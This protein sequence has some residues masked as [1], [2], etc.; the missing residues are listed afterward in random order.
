MSVGPL[1]LMNTHDLFFGNLTQDTLNELFQ[2]ASPNPNTDKVLLQEHINNRL[3]I[4]S[5]YFCK[6]IVKESYMKQT[7]NG[8]KKEK[9]CSIYINIYNKNYK[10]V[11]SDKKINDVHLT[12]HFFKKMDSDDEKRLGRIHIRNI[13][14]NRNQTI[15]ITKNN[16][17]HIRMLFIKYPHSPRVDLEPVFGTIIDVFND[18]LDPT[19]EL[20]LTKRLTDMSEQYHS[21]TNVVS[22]QQKS[23]YPSLK[24]EWTSSKNHSKTRRNT[25]NHKSKHIF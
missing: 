10:N 21:C 6:V 7:K 4:S 19:N 3:G 5:A 12:I 1:S 8:Y 2:R 13:N 17:N 9:M 23:S 24:K 15:K 25:S 20:S 22:S 16:N 18:Y 14:K 11:T